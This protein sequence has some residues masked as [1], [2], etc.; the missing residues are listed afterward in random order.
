MKEKNSKEK[1]LFEVAKLQQGL[2]TSK[3]AV[4]AGFGRNHHS[5]H[6]QAQN[7]FREMRGIYRL[8]QFLQDEAEAQ[9]VLWYL[10]SRDRQDIPKGVYS[11]QTALRIYDLTDLMPSQLHMT[12]P[13]NFRRFNQV[14]PIL[15][16]HKEEL[17]SSDIR[18]MSGYDVTTPTKTII[19]LVYSEQFEPELIEQAAKEAISKGMI[20]P[21]EMPRINSAL[22]S[23]ETGQPPKGS[24]RE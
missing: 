20:P 1:K 10:W 18:R 19:D 8:A 14:P 15:C 23:L 17:K 13:T 12:V 16:L 21:K 3:Q 5:Y 7:W 22:K 24:P 2:F 9:L 11:F 6:V 4:E